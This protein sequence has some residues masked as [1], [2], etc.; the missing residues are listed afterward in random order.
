MVRSVCACVERCCRQAAGRRRAGRTHTI[1][2]SCD[3]QHLTQTYPHTN[4][5]VAWT[6]VVGS[7]ALK[8]A[9]QCQY[10][11]QPLV[12]AQAPACLPCITTPPPQTLAFNT[13]T[14]RRRRDGSMP[15][16]TALIARP[17]HRPRSVSQ[18]VGQ[19]VSQS[20]TVR[21][22]PNAQFTQ[23]SQSVQRLRTHAAIPKASWH[24]VQTSN[25]DDFQVAGREVEAHRRNSTA[26]S[27]ARFL[28]HDTRPI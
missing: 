20:V 25:G 15:S 10:P 3:A 17:N 14:K 21:Q 28:A 19:S 5:H 22:H 16:R 8:C 24:G 13:R 27:L 11:S 2:A 26:V 23:V 1:C 12:C 9:R 6:Q 4:K 18:S 7:H